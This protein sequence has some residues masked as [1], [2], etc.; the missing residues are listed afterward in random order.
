LSPNF[1]TEEGGHYHFDITK[2]YIW[3]NVFAPIFNTCHQI[4]KIVWQIKKL[5][6]KHI[7]IILFLF[8]LSPLQASH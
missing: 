2:N 3:I 6:Q 7:Y 1:K 8:L 4:S 5:T